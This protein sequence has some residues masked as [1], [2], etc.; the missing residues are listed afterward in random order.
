M[1]G[2]CYAGLLPRRASQESDKLD[3]VF[4]ELNSLR[5]LVLVQYHVIQLV[6]GFLMWKY[7]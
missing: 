7:S 4:E 6:S 2:H 3:L 5:G 1:M